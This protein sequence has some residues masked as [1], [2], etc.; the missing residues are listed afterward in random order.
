[1]KPG[2]EVTLSGLDEAR[3]E[4]WGRRIGREVQTPVVLALSGELGAG[5]SVL[6]RAVARGAGVRGSIPSPTFNLVFHYPTAR[7]ATVVHLDLYRL[8]DPEELWELGWGELGQDPE[9]VLVEWPERAGSHLPEPRW[10]ISL[11]AEEGE[12]ELR[13]IRVRAVGTPPT[14]PDL[15]SE[16]PVAV[17]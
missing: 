6:A 3:V 17:P 13:T 7:D 16:R 9:I 2:V 8:E 1:M 10:D 14:L 4:A 5:K 15:P 11:A 12:L